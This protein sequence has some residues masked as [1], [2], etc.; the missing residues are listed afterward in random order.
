MKKNMILIGLLLLLITSCAPGS[1]I[2]V[3]VPATTLELTTPGPNPLV[4][5]ADNDGRLA[6]A[7]QGLWHGL[8]APVTLVGSFFNPALEMYEVHNNG[9]EYNLGFLVG[10]GLVF[11]LLGLI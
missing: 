6:G 10:V 5:E 1:D 11:L 3:N 7:A 4:N 8:I 9:R 2:E